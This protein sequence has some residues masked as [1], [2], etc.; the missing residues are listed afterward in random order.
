MAHPIDDAGCKKIYSDKFHHQVHKIEPKSID[1]RQWNNS[2]NGYEKTT[3][4]GV[5]RI[6]VSSRNQP[7]EKEHTDIQY[8]HQVINTGYACPV[9]HHIFFVGHFDIRIRNLFL[10]IDNAFQVE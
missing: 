6:V 3:A 1:N 7:G 8:N 5:K 4:N 10:F 2:Q 9:Y